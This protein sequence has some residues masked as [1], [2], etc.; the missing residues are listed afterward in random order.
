MKNN[1]RIVVIIM[2][3]LAGGMPVFA[4]TEAVSPRLSFHITNNAKVKYPILEIVDEPIFVD[5]DGNS[6][7]DAKENC[8]IVMKIKNTGQ[9]IGKGLTAR[10]TAEGTANGI[11]FSAKTK[12]ADIPVDGV[13]TVEFPITTDINTV[14]GKVTF[15]VSV[16]EPNGLGTEEKPIMI[17]TRKFRAPSV[18]VGDWVVSGENGGVLQKKEKFTLHVLVQNRGEGVAENVRIELERPNENV[19][20]VGGRLP[21]FTCPELAGGDTLDIKYE[22][23]VN[24]LYNEPTLPFKVKISESYGKYARDSV[25]T[26]TLNQKLDNRPI[27]V[28]A[29]IAQVEIEDFSLTSDVDRNIPKTDKQYPNRFALII[30]NED[31]ESKGMYGTKGQNV[32]YAS[33]DAEVFKKYC[34]KMLGID[35]KNIVFRK[36]ATFNEMTRGVERIVSLVNSRMKYEQDAEIVF[37]YAGHGLPD[38]EKIPYLIPVDVNVGDLEHSSISMYNLCTKLSNTHALRVTVFLD[39]CFSGGARDKSLLAEQRAMIITP[40]K[41]VLTGN[42]V[43]FSATT[44][45][46]S[47]LPYNKK[48]HGMFTYFL[49]KKLQESEGK[50]TYSQLF[51]YVIRK[52]S[53]QSVFDNDQHQDPTYQVSPAAEQDN[54][55]DWKFIDE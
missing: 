46:Q 50:C 15:K 22:L 48:M 19:L 21:V 27:E 52:V 55:R 9:G 14:D 3:L 38:D 53:Y 32:P 18:V 11:S 10:I 30:G 35:E 39:A 43:V 51:D 4:Q 23:L 13:S 7:I 45:E 47:A 17:Q 34:I 5:V 25:I 41:E 20:W 28:E 31:Y 33:V 40:N 36:D 1:Y 6:V 24:L 49:L 16:D 8:K 42:T 26:L 37:Y 12:L 54:W 29:Q 2:M 44:N